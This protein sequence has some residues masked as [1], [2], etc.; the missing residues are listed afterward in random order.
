MQL[1]KSLLLKHE[2]LG[3]DSQH[4]HKSLAGIVMCVC[5]PSVGEA[6]TGGPLDGSGQTV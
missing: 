5:N 4:T 3:L 2:D 1:L 6:E